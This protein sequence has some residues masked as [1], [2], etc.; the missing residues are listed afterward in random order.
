[1]GTEVG[2]PS[3][4]SG[5]MQVKSIALMHTEELWSLGLNARSRNEGQQGY[6]RERADSGMRMPP[7][8]PP[9]YI[10]FASRAASCALSAP[11]C[12]RAP[13]R[14]CSRPSLPSAVAVRLA[15]ARLAAIVR[16]TCTD[17]SHM[18]GAQGLTTPSEACH[19]NVLRKVV[20]QV[21]KGHHATLLSGT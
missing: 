15:T 16:S 9:L 5:P 20:W 4:P 19:E 14:P 7:L 17:G 12:F 13:S 18:L 21:E 3:R 6:L 1:M 2:L 10:C 11:S 8:L